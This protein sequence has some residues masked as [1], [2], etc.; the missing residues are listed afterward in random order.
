MRVDDLPIQPSIKMELSNQCF[1]HSEC[2]YMSLSMLS[3]G[4]QARLITDNLSTA[5]Y[6]YS[7]LVADYAWGR[8]LDG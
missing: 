3:V 7:M 8:S 4:D 6:S 5:C 1:L 2:L